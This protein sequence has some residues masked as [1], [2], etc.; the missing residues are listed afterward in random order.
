MKLAGRDLAKSPPTIPTDKPF[1]L[2]ITL[3]D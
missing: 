1:T 3:A 2:D